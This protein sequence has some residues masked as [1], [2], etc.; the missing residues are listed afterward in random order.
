MKKFDKKLEVHTTYYIN[1]FSYTQDTQLKYFF[2][3]KVNR[4]SLLFITY[5]KNSYLFIR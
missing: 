5:K 1:I 2:T 3:I 4:M